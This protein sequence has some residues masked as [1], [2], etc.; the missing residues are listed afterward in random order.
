MHSLRLRFVAEVV[1]VDILDG[2]SAA[3]RRTTLL[4][5]N[6]DAHVPVLCLCRGEPGAPLSVVLARGTYFLRRF[7][8]TALAH[9]AACPFSEPPRSSLGRTSN[10]SAVEREDDGHIT[11]RLEGT[12][13]FPIRRGEKVGT[14]GKIAPEFTGDKSRNGQN[15]SRMGMLGLLKLLFEEAG[16]HLWS[17]NFAQRRSE[18]AMYSFVRRAAQ[19]I[20]LGK[21]EPLP[22]ASVMRLP[23]N[24]L[25]EEDSVRAEIAA[26]P[27]KKNGSSELLIFGRISKLL[28][29]KSGR[30]VWLTMARIRARFYL[31][32]EIWEDFV[33]SHPTLPGRMEDG[34]LERLVVVLAAVRITPRA[35]DPRPP[36]LEITAISAQQVTDQFVPVES[37][38][39]AIAVDYLIDA[40]RAFEKPMRMG[41]E[42]DMF[43]DIVL[44]DTQPATHFEVWGMGTPEYL[45]RRAQK[46]ALCAEKQIPLIGWDAAAGA[47]FPEAEL[48]RFAKR[49]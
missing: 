6:H 39:E 9:D 7:K 11:V 33:K 32:P 22:M 5:A 13:V 44:V 16:L 28:P 42:D 3:E 30:G 37:R 12:E 36:L 24:E 49:S 35:G 23:M 46:E 47:P 25:V 8:D 40:R 27:V 2:P 41:K 26:S 20:T 21:R 43:P 48:R 1:P 45:A 19:K 14:E 18:G 38:F 34:T 4:R 10:S 15:R 17:P 29:T 31:S